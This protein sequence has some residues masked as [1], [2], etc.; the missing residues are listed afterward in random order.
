MD[1][2]KMIAASFGGNK[3]SRQVIRQVAHREQKKV[4]RLERKRLAA[5]EL[6]ELRKK[7]SG[8]SEDE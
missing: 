1:V 8:R 7:R 4:D 2:K 6:I 3:A 5:E